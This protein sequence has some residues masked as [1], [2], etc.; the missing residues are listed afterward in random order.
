MKKG[1]SFTLRFAILYGIL[2]ILLYTALYLIIARYMN[3]SMED[4]AF[5][6]AEGTSR[7]VFNS[8]YQFIKRG[9]ERKDLLEFIKS[10]ESSYYGT[11]ISINLY[12]SDIVKEIFGDAPEPEKT[13]LHEF[14]LK[15]QTQRLSKD[16][17]YTY[18]TPV[19]ASKDC[20]RCHT[21]AKE[22]DILGLVET[23]ISLKDFATGMKALFII[24]LLLPALVFS[25]LFFTLIMGFRGVL[26]SM[27]K[28]AS[29]NVKDIKSLEDVG[30]IVSLV[31]NSYNEIKPI[32]EAIEHLSKKVKSIA[33]DKEVLEL[34]FK[35]L[36]K[37]ILTS[38]AIKEWHEYV[39]DLVKEMNSIIPIDIIFVLFL[40][41]NEIRVNVFWYKRVEGDM[42]DYIEDFIK[43]KISLELPISLLANKQ[44]YFNHYISNGKEVFTEYDKEKIRLRTKAVFL[45]KPQLGA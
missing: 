27:S 18:I 32:Y 44:V 38:R 5:K 8:M 16:Y 45:D 1:R 30:K 3:S 40:E 19:K 9:W 7:Q 36:E 28:E 4:V 41:D 24:L 21:N 11:F 14:A 42:K 15:G 35:L 33:I 22:G 6:V 29:K 43:S 10:V 34:E 23:R 13:K 31:E 39:K 37:I 2:A 26:V 12:R 20:L 25:F 17:V